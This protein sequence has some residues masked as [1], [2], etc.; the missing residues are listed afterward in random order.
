MSSDVHVFVLW[1]AAAPQSDR[2]VADLRQKFELLDARRITWAPDRFTDNVRGF[3]GADLPERF[4][5]AAG[6]GAGPFVVYVVRDPEPV[7]APRLRSS[8]E[9]PPANVKAYDS[10]Q[11]YREWTGGGFRIHATNTPDEA[12]RD[13]SLLLGR[14]LESYAGAP[15]ISW[16][17]EPLA[18]AADVVGARHRP[19]RWPRRLTAAGAVRGLKRRA[20]RLA[21]LLAAVSRPVRR[22]RLENE[23]RRATI[24]ETSSEPG[25]ESS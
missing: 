22:R 15:A 5:K 6:S 21:R 11:L 25:D 23:R 24:R 10:K 19:R 12:A 17:C 3:Y 16:D 2:I 8:G 1:S 20:R 13:V 9:S 14:T 7:Y 4:D 18:F